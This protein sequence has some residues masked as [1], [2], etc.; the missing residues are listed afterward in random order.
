VQ[1]LRHLIGYLQHEPRV[2][3]ADLGEEAEVGLEE[4]R[5]VGEVAVDVS[6]GGDAA[7]RQAAYLAEDRADDV[8][9]IPV[10]QQDQL[11][12]EGQ[13]RR[14]G[15][16]LVGGAQDREQRLR[17]ALRADQRGEGLLGAVVHRLQGRVHP[18]P[19]R[20]VNDL[21]ANGTFTTSFVICYR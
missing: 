19:F 6:T 7:Q 21:L 8:V 13:G 9:R 15:A 20:V 10:E 3:L 12:E 17:L 14:V 1:H 5:E 2:L 18:T 16:Y 11:L 4:V